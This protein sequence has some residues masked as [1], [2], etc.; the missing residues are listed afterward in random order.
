MNCQ[1]M[2]RVSVS[3]NQMLYRYGKEPNTHDMI[4]ALAIISMIIDH[5]G[6]LY[7]D[8]NVYCRTI[9][10]IAAPLF[11]FLIGYS[12][13]YELTWKL[14]LSG[15]FLTGFLWYCRGFTFANILLV[16]LVIRWLFN[17]WN[18]SNSSWWVLALLFVSL[19]PF[20]LM[21]C[22]FIEYG[23]LG[24]F[25]AIAGRLSIQ[26][27]TK[28]AKNLAFW[29]LVATMLSSFFWLGAVFKIFQYELATFILLLECLFLWAIMHYYVNRTWSVWHLTG[30]PI[31][32]L[33]RFSLEI[34]VGH[35]IVLF[36]FL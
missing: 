4:K 25:W 1:V 27:E 28:E 35:L 18:P 17:R 24:L 2:S 21:L 13:K 15:V 8:N 31:M 29:W 7:V 22:R 36:L 5:V 12:K 16:F 19:T 26:K 33:S 20:F 10:R 30:Y 3:I 32:I 34:Y 6:W 14:Y 11:F 9:G 23:Q